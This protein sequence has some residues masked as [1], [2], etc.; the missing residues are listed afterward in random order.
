M[1]KGREIVISLSISLITFICYFYFSIFPKLQARVLL[2]E[3][4]IINVDKNY[5]H[6]LDTIEKD[7]REINRDIKE[8]L[9]LLR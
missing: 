9:K 7:I 1:K 3:N 4:N 2:L 8:I 5:S 6:S